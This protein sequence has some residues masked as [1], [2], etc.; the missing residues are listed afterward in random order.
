MTVGVTPGLT[1]LVPF[2]DLSTSDRRHRPSRKCGLIRSLTVEVSAP[3]CPITVLLSSSRTG[4]NSRHLRPKE[5]N[6]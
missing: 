2:M 6:A 4:T 1:G 5:E 3:A